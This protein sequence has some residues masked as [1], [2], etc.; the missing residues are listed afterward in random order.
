MSLELIQFIINLAGLTVA[1][2]M[3]VKSRE[4]EDYVW[5]LMLIASIPLLLLRLNMLIENTPLLL[6]YLVSLVTGISIAL[7]LYKFALMGGA[8]AKALIVLSINEIP[9]L[10]KDPLSLLPP[11]S[12]FVNSTLFSLSVIPFILARNTFYFLTRGELFKGFEKEDIKKKIICL[13]TAYKVP[14]SAYLKNKY[15]Y[16]LAESRE[17]GEKKLRIGVRLEEEEE[18]LNDTHSEEEVWVSPLL[19]LIVFIEIGYI[20]YFFWGNI[21]GFI[22]ASI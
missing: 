16:S 11:L 21:V 22:L 12:I 13:L 9:L 4:I 6:L 2:Y 8:D 18:E 19:P 17:N 15:M 14:F 7:I 20:A 1:S 10:H 5:Y 3:D